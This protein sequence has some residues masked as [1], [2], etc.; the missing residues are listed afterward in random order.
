MLSIVFENV[1]SPDG[2]YI[3]LPSACSAYTSNLTQFNFFL[4]VLGNTNYTIFS[5][6]NF[7]QTNANGM[8]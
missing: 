3:Y 6:A 7:A 1:S 2:K 5:L 4:A 8:C